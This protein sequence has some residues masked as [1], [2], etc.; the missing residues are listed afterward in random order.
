MKIN[1]QSIILLLLGVILIF[2]FTACATMGKRESSAKIAVTP[3]QT[4]LSPA[5][6]KKPIVI[7]GSGWKAGEMVVV[8]MKLP[9]GVTVKGAEPGED[10]GIAFGNADELG[11]L[12]TKVGAITIL[13]SFFQVGWDNAKMKPDFKVAKPLPPGAYVLEAIGMESEAKA[14][15][16]LTLVAPPKKKN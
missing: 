11:N 6:I 13:M 15:A 16:V 10:V 9:E 1:R 7:T 8:N 12:N 4:V 2:T 5:L 3:E 14:D